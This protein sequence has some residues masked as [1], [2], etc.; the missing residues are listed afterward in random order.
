MNYHSDTIRK[1]LLHVNTTY[2][3]PALQREFVWTADQVV[4][5]MTR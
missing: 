1:I 5:Y 3:L 4:H 2:Y